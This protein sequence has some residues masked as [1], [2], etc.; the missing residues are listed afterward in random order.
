MPTTKN[1]YL[2]QDKE[3]TWEE[4]EKHCLVYK[5]HLPSIHSQQENDFIRGKCY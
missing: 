3:V 1:W 4:A 5:A 2:R